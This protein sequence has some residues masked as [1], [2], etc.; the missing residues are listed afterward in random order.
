MPL[1]AAA[2][3]SE[4]NELVG[5]WIHGRL[6]STQSVYLPVIQEFRDF[7]DG[8]P[9][10]AVTLKHL[11]DFADTFSDQKPATVARK[12]ATV[13]S[14]LTFTHKIGMIPFDVGRALRSPKVTDDLNEKIL[15]EQDIHRMI[16]M[17]P[18]LR[19][20][21]LLRILYGTGIRAAE[22]AGLTWLSV[23]PRAGGGGQISVLGKG[24]KIRSILLSLR[25]WDA[26]MR[27]KPERPGMHTPVFC[28]DDGRAMSRT[29]VTTV[30]SRAARRAGIEQHVSAHWLR[31][32]HASHALDRGAK[33]TVIQMTLGHSNLKTTSRYLHARPDESS[34]Q[35][36]DS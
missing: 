3:P 16:E 35:Y 23:Q 29:H 36:V 7:V 1:R 8:I 17:E 13:R 18:I 26:L 12:L 33:L 32:G 27:I 2:A 5:L 30:V 31:H 34:A 10:S 9:I 6:E 11:Q 28:R 15:T 21:V 25:A 4:W 24:R 19:N 20:Q 22:A 14:L